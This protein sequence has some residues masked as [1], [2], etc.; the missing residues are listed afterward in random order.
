LRVLNLV[1]QRVRAAGASLV[2]SLRPSIGSLKLAA[3]VAEPRVTAVSAYPVSRQVLLDSQIRAVLARDTLPAKA[4]R[5]RLAERQQTAGFD[6]MP[7]LSQISV[8]E[9]GTYLENVLLRD[10]DQMSMAHAL[11]VRVPFLDH[12]LVEL[13]LRVPDEQKYP[14][15]PKRLLV[16][17]LDG[18]L[19]R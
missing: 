5:R 8:A 1:P 9:L 4:V 10:T 2:A 3:A 11:E 15:T 16:E 14:T 18:L 12:E 19:P 13:M 6:S 7:L 17:A